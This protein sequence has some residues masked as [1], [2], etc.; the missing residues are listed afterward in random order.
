METNEEN[1]VVMDGME[2]VGFLW[3]DMADQIQLKDCKCVVVGALDGQYYIIVIRNKYG[4]INGGKDGVK[5]GTQVG[6]I[7]RGKD[8]DK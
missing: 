8:K 4:G 6:D 3:F 5:D 2:E 7:Y 1:Y